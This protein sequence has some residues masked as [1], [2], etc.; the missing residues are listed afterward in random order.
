MADV[1][2]EAHPSSAADTLIH[3][4]GPVAPLWSS[5]TA[6]QAVSR[7]GRSHP[8]PVPGVPRPLLSSASD[9]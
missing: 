1:S 8:V 2:P 4:P 5:R 9:S 3:S 7:S 6:Q